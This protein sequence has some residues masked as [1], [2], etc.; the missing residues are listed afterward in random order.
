MPHAWT[1]QANDDKSPFLQGTLNFPMFEDEAPATFALY[2]GLTFLQFI[3]IMAFLIVVPWVVQREARE[4]DFL[5]TT[6]SD[7]AVKVRA[8]CVCCMCPGPLN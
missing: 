4:A 1:I 7:F 6:P 8:L 5:R 3:C 2:C